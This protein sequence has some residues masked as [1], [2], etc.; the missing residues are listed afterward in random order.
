MHEQ[1]EELR[2]A[3]V[4]NG[5]VS[6]AVWMGGVT[7]EIFRIVKGQHPVYAELLAMTHTTARVDVISG[8]SAGGINGAALSL[9]LLYRGDFARLRQVW[10][11]TG[12][13]ASLLRA[14]LGYNPGSLLRGDDFFLPE[15]QEA[16]RGLARNSTPIPPDVMPIDLRLT[17]TLLRGEQGNSV[18]DLGTPIHDVDY[19]AQFRFRNTSDKRDFKDREPLV[20]AISRAAR[21][22]ASFPFAFEPS[23]VKDLGDWFVDSSDQPIAASK[24][25]D[26]QTVAPRF[27]VD[28]GVLNNKP[29]RGALRSIFSMPAQSGVRRVLAYINPTRATA[30]PASRA[31]TCRRFPACWPPAC[32][33]SLNRSRSQ[34]SSR[35]SRTT[36][37]TFARAGTAC[38]T[39]SSP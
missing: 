6:L 37:T 15:I 27:V 39:P 20:A 13:F 11:D 7:N 8:T 14:P 34:T 4:M 28:G 33:G 22:T 36:T 9:A 10:L 2:L 5:G 25:E 19:R 32:S 21:S 31:R 38:S 1:R 26:T 30:R 16:F 23:A 24:L 18:D 35:R 17:T 29:F 3:L 12:A